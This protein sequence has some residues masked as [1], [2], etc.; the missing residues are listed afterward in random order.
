MVKRFHAI[1]VGNVQG[2]FYRASARD[3]AM[4]L[5]LIGFVRNL[6]DGSVELEAEGEEDGLRELLQWCNHGPP[7]AT[8]KEVKVDWKFP[9]NIGGN[10][11]ILR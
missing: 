11:E 8:V 5:G 4:A 1:V 3:Q 10:F 2:V 9:Q 6:P 7:S